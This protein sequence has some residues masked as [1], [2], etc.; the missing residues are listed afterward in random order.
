M[1]PDTEARLGSLERRIARLTAACAVL[2][3]GLAIAVA[4]HFVPRPALDA[5]RFM[6]RDSVGTWRGALM[7]R[8]DG[9]PVLRLNDE[10]SRARLYGVV[11]PD[12]RPRLRLLDSTGVTRTVL[13]LEPSGEPSVRLTGADGRS[14]V[15]AGIDSTGS[16]W[17]EVRGTGGV[18]SVHSAA[19]APAP[20]NKE[21]RPP[22]R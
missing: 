22:R 4:W 9:S 14:R 18:R 19:G 11:T 5:S 13:E 12:G 21:N 20:A 16:G 2:A 7:L 6:L 15:H 1:S 10:R 8:E 17:A 3:A